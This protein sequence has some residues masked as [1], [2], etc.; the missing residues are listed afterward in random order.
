VGGGS[1]G[2][3]PVRFCDSLDAGH[4]FCEDFDAPDADVAFTHFTYVSD[5]DAGGVVLD[6]AQFA[7]GPRS[8]QAYLVPGTGSCYFTHADFAVPSTAR[9]A[10]VD[11][12]VR[13]GAGYTGVFGAIGFSQ[14]NVGACQLLLWQTTD[15]TGTVT[16]AGVFGLL[17]QGLPWGQP[18]TY[19]DGFSS[20]SPI[21]PDRWFRVGLDYDV[22]NQTLAMSIDGT[23]VLDGGLQHPCPYS[24]TDTVTLSTGLL[25]VDQPAARWQVW[26]DDIVFDTE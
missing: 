23:P 9:R 24:A 6:L 20:L 2:G 19:S 15:A 11:M 12:S 26:Y 22:A 13:I 17:D 7:T 5:G 1:G 8:M 25:C 16:D 10:R 4:L 14:N 18:S 21:H 3:A